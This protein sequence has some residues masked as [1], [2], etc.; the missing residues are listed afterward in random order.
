MEAFSAWNTIFLKDSAVIFFLTLS[1]L[2]Q[3]Y[4][5]N[6]GKLDIS[7]IFCNFC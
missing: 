3:S 4:L 2:S 6:P 7:N 1:T 5:L